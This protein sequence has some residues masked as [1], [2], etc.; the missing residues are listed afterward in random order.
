MISSTFTI[1]FLVGP[2]STITAFLLLTA[3]QTALSN[4]A[5]LGP[6]AVNLRT[7]ANYAILAKSGVSTVPKSVISM[8]SNPEF[9]VAYLT[10][11]CSRQCRRQPNRRYR[12]DR[13]LPHGRLDWTIFDLFSSHRPPLCGVVLRPYPVDADG[14]H[15]RHGDRIY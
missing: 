2:S 12:P 8:S 14:R 7:A 3:A 13:L 9:I 11:A 6:A 15:R 1:C 10:Y 5:A 4:V